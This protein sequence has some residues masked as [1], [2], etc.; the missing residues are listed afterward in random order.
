MEWSVL[1][2][3]C[4]WSH[5]GMHLGT[6]QVSGQLHALTALHLEKAPDWAH[7]RSQRFG[8]NFKLCPL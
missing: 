5:S 4:E 2:G 3:T 1:L 6:G 8:E 7:S